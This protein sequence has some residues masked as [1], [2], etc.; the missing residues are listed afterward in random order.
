[1]RMKESAPSLRYHHE[2][3]L[4]LLSGA[5]DPLKQTPGRNNWLNNPARWA[6]TRT[7]PQPKNEQQTTNNATQNRPTATAQCQLLINDHD[8]GVS[9]EHT[10]LVS[11][12]KH[13]TVLRSP[14][15]RRKS[16]TR[17]FKSGD[18]IGFSN[19]LSDP[20]LI[21]FDAG[22]GDG[23]GSLLME[24][25]SWIAR[26]SSIKRSWRSLL[27]QASFACMRLNPKP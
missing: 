27:L 23:D 5:G 7:Q 14:R 12:R 6:F 17:W 21:R 1:M 26:G 4:C 24:Q 2:P 22:D 18:S 11:A 20:S 8:K 13:F 16:T 3:N 25:R 10:K 19:G 9:R 15:F